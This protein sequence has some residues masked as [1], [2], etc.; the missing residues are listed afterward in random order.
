MKEH[1]AKGLCLTHYRR[2]YS[3]AYYHRKKLDP[4]WYARF[5]AACRRSGRKAAAQKAALDL[6]RL[7]AE[8]E[9]RS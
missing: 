9:A 2:E 1:Y 5:T 3:L 6:A 4:A 7:A 8:L